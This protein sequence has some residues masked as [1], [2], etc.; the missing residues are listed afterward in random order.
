MSLRTPKGLDKGDFFLGLRAII[1]GL[2]P[3]PFSATFNNTATRTKCL[4]ERVKIHLHY[5]IDEIV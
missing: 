3:F 4:F 5:S 2:K 1:Y